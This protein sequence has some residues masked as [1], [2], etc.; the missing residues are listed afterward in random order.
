MSAPESVAPLLLLLFAG[1]A[2]PAPAADIDN[3][4]SFGTMGKGR[5]LLRRGSETE[6][7]RYSGRGCLTHMWFGGDFKDYGRTRIRIYVDGEKQ[8]SIDMELMMGHGIGFQDDAAPWGIERIGK[9]G[10]PSGIYDT[11][12][13]RL[14]LD[15]RVTAE[16]PNEDPEDTVFW[17]VIS[18][19]VNLA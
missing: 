13:I 14:G 15:I 6:L 2:F 16:S 8:A 4:K 9:T 12:R 17:L 3:V 18:G 11:Y 19:V 1:A 5:R 10:Q 7:F